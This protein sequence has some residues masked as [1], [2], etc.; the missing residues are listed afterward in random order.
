MNELT[1]AIR[2]ASPELLARLVYRYTLV[3]VTKAA[4]LL[5]RRNDGQRPT[6]G[7][8]WRWCESQ[9]AAA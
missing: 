5:A 3:G 9:A 4:A 7:Q 2:D 1:M 6:V 8:V